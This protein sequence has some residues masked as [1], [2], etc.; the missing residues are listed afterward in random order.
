MNDRIKF[1]LLFAL[2]CTVGAFAQRPPKGRGPQQQ[3]GYGAPSGSYSNQVSLRISGQY[4]YVT[5]NGIPVHD[6]GQ[7]PNRNNPNSIRPQR[8]SYR[9]PMNP[10]TNRVATTFNLMPF[11]I[12]LNGVLFDPNAA[13]FWRRDF[14]SGW[15]YE[16]KDG[17]ID[18]GLDEHNAHVQPNG[19]YH[20]HAMP[21]GLARRLF[22][23]GRPVL[24]GYAA[25][26]FPIYARYGYEKA[27]DPKS[28]LVEM[29]SSYRVKSGARP[30]GPGGSHDGTFIQD[31]EYVAGAGDLDECNGRF[32]VT[33]EY[34]K[35]I[36]HYY[37]TDTWPYLP[38]KFRGT[39]DD[40]FKRRGPPPGGRGGP[41]GG[42]GAPPGFG[43]PGQR[44][45]GF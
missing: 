19:A 12:A 39:P 1:I 17:S 41:G 34:P 28:E 29:K 7:F 32:G 3:R 5:A 33:P 4:R 38:R 20:Y 40:S 15:Q 11:G 18:L 30:N 44:P 21:T 13:E 25:D 43:P 36:Y 35:G 37:I 16:A 24:V 14:N 10:A 45:R 2:V 6:P 22:V 9:L 26:G 27:N 23:D 42:R 31:Y 8:Y